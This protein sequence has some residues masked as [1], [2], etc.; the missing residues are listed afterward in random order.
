ML[1]LSV[2]FLVWAT[3]RVGSVISLLG[4]AVILSFSFCKLYLFLNSNK[5]Y[6][7]HL[8]IKFIPTNNIIIK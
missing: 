8:L 5:L 3:W 1:L 2:C 4:Q 6:D 7:L